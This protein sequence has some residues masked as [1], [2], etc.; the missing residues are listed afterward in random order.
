MKARVGPRNSSMSQR[1]SSSATSGAT[2]GWSKTAYDSA[3][4]ASNAARSI[5]PA[6]NGHITSTA[7]AA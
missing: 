7:V 3:V 2:S 1:P 4:S 5:S 6:T